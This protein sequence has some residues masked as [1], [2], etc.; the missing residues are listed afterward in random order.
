M[1]DRSILGRLARLSK[2]ERD[3]LVDELDPEER[4]LLKWG[5]REV[6][7]RPEQVIDWSNPARV[8]LLLTGRGFG[9]TRTLIEATIEMSLG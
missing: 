8:H 6:L 9:K 3:E 5:W 1:A 4:Y 2:A 7:A